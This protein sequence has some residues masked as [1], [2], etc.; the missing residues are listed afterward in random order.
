MLN[1]RDLNM[2]TWEERVMAGDARF[3]GS[4]DAPDFP[5]AE[6]ARSL[7][8]G[9]IRVDNPDQI[10]A[11]WDQAF[12]SDRPFLVE[13][14]TDPNVPPLPPHISFEQARDFTS[15]VLHRDAEALGFIKQTVKEVAASIRPHPKK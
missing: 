4:Q 15:S 13:A 8:L 7:G 12:R 6:Y 11:A 2:V 9:G 5:Y 3:E 1:N 10:G 14:V